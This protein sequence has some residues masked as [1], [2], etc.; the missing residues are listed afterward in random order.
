MRLLE[1]I[2]KHVFHYSFNEF[3]IL[4]AI[5][6]FTRYNILQNKLGCASGGHV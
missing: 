1:L 3:N 5:D 4:Q 6:R 2:G